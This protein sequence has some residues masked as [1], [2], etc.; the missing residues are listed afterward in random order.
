MVYLT[1]HYILDRCLMA[2]CANCK[3]HLL[4]N[5]QM[6]TI[7]RT[8]HVVLRYLCMILTCTCLN[9][10]FTYKL[11]LAIYSLLHANNAAF[12]A[13][14]IIRCILCYSVQ[15]ANF[16]LVWNSLHVLY[17]Y[18]SFVCV[19]ISLQLPERQLFAVT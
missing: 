3:K 14:L 10:C 1:Q 13:P 8:R 7:Q 4:F 17:Y 5:R 16:A 2:G 18:H 11:S 12:Y 19:F 6:Q 9:G 15:P